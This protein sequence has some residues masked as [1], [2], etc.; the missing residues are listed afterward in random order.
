MLDKDKRTTESEINRTG[1]GNGQN[2]LVALLLVIILSIG[3]YY[4]FVGLNWDDYTHLHPDERFLTQVLAGLGGPVNFTGEDAQT[5]YATCLERY[6]DEEGRGLYFNGGYFDSQCSALNPNNIGFGLYVYGTLPLFIADVGSDRFADLAYQY[7]V[8]QADRLGVD[9][10]PQWDF[11]VWRGYNGAHIVW[12]A[13][14]GASDLLAAFFL[15]LIGR[16]LH[17]KWA[18]LLAAALYIAAPLPIQKAHFATVNSM[19]NL[20]GVLSLYFAVRVQDKGHLGDYA[21]FGLAFAAS[22]ASRINLVPL[23]VLILFAAG[24][25]MLPAFDW[26]LAWGERNRIIGR[27]FGGLVLA[28]VITILAFR[29]FQPYAFIGPN[30]GP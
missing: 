29:I 12:R 30:P 1:G 20:F 3:S 16:R 19:A 11:D 9:P 14:N 2:A 24:L 21:L 6:P 17:G 15:F 22:L 5:R 28:G 4:R 23:V 7:E 10:D 25:R 26:R 8:W 27:E 13:L 18:G